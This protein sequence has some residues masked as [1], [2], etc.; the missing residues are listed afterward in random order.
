VDSLRPPRPL[1]LLVRDAI[2][3]LKVTV[4]L[5]SAAI[6]LVFAGT[7]AQVDRGIWTVMDQYFRCYV[8]WI[9]LR[10]FFPMGEGMPGKFPFPGGKLLGTALIVNMLVAHFSRIRVKARGG[11]LLLGLG[12]LGTGAALTWIMISHVFDLDSSEGTTN[13]SLRVTYQLL[14]GGGAAIVLFMGC[15]MVFT[16]KAGIVLLH[17]GVVL[18]M[19]SELITA[20]FAKETMMRIH[21]GQTVS[22]AEDTRMSELAV[23]TSADG[24]TDDVVVVPDKILRRGGRIELPGLPLEIEV[25]PARYMKNSGLREAKPGDENPATTG[26]G[27]RWIAGPRREGSGVDTSAGVDMPAVYVTFRE[28]GRPE[29]IGTLLVAV[30]LTYEHVVQ[31]VRAGGKDYGVALRF[32]RVYKPY[33][34]YLYDFKFDRYLGTDKPK[35]FS[36][37]VR[38][39]DPERHVSRDVRI[40]MNNPL[41]YRGDTLYQADWDKESEAGTVLQVVENRGWMVPYVACMIVAVGLLGQFLLHLFGFLREQAEQA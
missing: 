6:F 41:R 39:E 15:W 24:A 21:E 11:R 8:A 30:E 10:L 20:T 13:P 34:L 32:E 7:L 25:D 37:Y 22:Y 1:P 12:V 17:F 3:S 38:L 26:A 2:G 36:S 31:T 27:L 9:E 28:K 4:V 40:W 19:A 14:Q 5:L 33:S 18:L 35:D 16:R 29:P 23:W